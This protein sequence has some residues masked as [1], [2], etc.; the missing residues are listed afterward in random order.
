MSRR[1]ACSIAA[2]VVVLTLACSRATSPELRRLTVDEVAARIAAHDGHTFVYDDNSR[3]RY[4]QGH[5]PGA[6]WVESGAVTA[7]VLPADKTAT[8]I[9]YCANEW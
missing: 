5:L 7:A 3:E 1:G 2:F 8:L 6:R 9:F 4:E